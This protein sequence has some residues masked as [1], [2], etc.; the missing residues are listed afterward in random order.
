MSIFNQIFT[1]TMRRKKWAKRGAFRGTATRVGVSNL[2]A[3]AVIGERDQS[4]GA[5]PT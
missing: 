4:R 3:S 1:L 5:T 2:K